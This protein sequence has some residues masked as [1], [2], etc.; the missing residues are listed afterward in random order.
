M[1]GI[2]AVFCKTPLKNDSKL[3]KIKKGYETLKSRGPDSGNFTNEDGNILGFHRLCINDMSSSGDQPMIYKNTKLMCNGEIYNHKQLEKQFNIKCTSTSDCE[4]ILKLFLK[5]GFE[6][7]VSLL[8]GVFAIV[9]T[10]GDMVYMARDRIGVRPLFSGTTEDGDLA[11]ASVAKALHGFCKDIK[12]VVPGIIIIDKKTREI[13]YK[14]YGFTRTPVIDPEVDLRLSLTDAV[15]KRLLTDRPIGCLLS[16][17]LDSSLVASLLC[18]LMNPS[19][20]RTYSIGMKG[21]SDL[22]YAKNVADYLGTTHTE[23]IFTPEEGLAVIPE[24]IEALESYDIT[25]IRASIPMF[26]LSKYIKENTKDRVI[27]SG[28]GSDELL[29]GYLYFHFSPTPQD[30]EKESR[31]LVNDLYKYDVLRADRTVSVHGL[32]LR[33]P[34]LDTEF[35]QLAMS[36]KGTQ[37]MPI[38]NYE[39]FILRSAFK[40]KYLPDNILWRRKCAFSDGVSP[41]HKSWFEII[42]DYADTQVS[43]DKFKNSSYMSKESLLYKQIFDKYFPNY[44]PIIEMWMPKWTNAKDP[45]ARVFYNGNDKDQM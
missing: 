2:I 17:G 8:D 12:Q 45:S 36:M 29:C 3:E 7:T 9:I 1:C 31:R 37:K 38:N 30:L 28:E 14:T 43:D 25:T 27:F 10:Q 6:K 19:D 32:E 13:D 20:V 34:F 4:I 42:Q 44:Q 5:I 41:T 18:K 16:G 24:V 22:K 23:V 26:L 40:G 39:K 11:V 35:V 15:K 33:V 21:S